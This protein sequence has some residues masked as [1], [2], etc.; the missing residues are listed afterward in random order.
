MH[1]N[2]TQPERRTKISNHAIGTWRK[3]QESNVDLVDTPKKRRMANKGKKTRK[4]K[5]RKTALKREV[6]DTAISVAGHPSHLTPTE[7]MLVASG[8][9]V[10]LSVHVP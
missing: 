5:G 2:S 8:I 10:A 7:H 3:R 6:E 1:P 4:G 9:S